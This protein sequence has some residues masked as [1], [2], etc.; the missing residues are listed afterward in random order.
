MNIRNDHA[1]SI[2]GMSLVEALISLLL[3]S[4]IM[5]AFLGI[6]DST[7]RVARVQGNIADSTENLR[8]SMAALVRVV[9]MAG[10]G[11]IPIVSENATGK[12]PIAIE[13]TD[14]LST[15]ESWGGKP[16]ILGTDILR[17]RG[18]IVGELYEI[19]GPN[20]IDLSAG[21]VKVP[22]KSP[23]L[24]RDQA[25]AVPNPPEK[26]PLVFASAQPLNISTSIGGA[27]HYNKYFMAD[28][29]DDPDA[30]G[31]P[32]PPDMDNIS[33]MT[34]KFTTGGES[35]ALNH[36]ESSTL[37]T[38]PVYAAG[39]VDDMRFFIAEN[40]S[41]EMSL[42][43]FLGTGNAEELVPNIVNLQ[44][45]LGCDINRDGVLADSEWFHSKSTPAAPTFDQ[46]NSIR[47]IRLS[48][49]ARSQEI[50]NKWSDET[51][52][53]ENSAQ[54]AS[55]QV[56]FRHRVMTV[57]TGLRSHPGLEAS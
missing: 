19:D 1:P 27:R 42:Y 38:A 13:V 11:G 50:D 49:V 8:F 28:T 36:K 52:M 16:V 25:L 55:D 31:T 41:G 35:A 54:L 37:D 2:R 10:T 32:T 40:A 15:T 56:K 24:G 45:A 7:T 23:F 26:K 39:F 22:S 46:L 21:T 44:V 43:R 29:L 34:A 53:P 5:V 9:R 57:R 20:A 6:L 51:L 48:L 18:V 33:Y 30:V 14:N 12:F 4:L 3:L 47:E 17:I